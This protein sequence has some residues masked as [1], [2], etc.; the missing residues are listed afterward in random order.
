MILSLMNP[1]ERTS[2]A[3]PPI[4]ETHQVLLQLEAGDTI[5]QQDHLRGV[6][7]RV[8]NIVHVAKF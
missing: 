3:D 1:H 7:P 8:V 4:T 2:P 5:Y 6:L